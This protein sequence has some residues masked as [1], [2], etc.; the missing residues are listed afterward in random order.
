MGFYYVCGAMVGG[1]KCVART[2]SGAA[3]VQSHKL[4]RYRP[5]NKAEFDRNYRR[6]FGVL[7]AWCRGTGGDYFRE[8]KT[9]CLICNGVG[10]T[11]KPCGRKHSRGDVL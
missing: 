5:V 9:P 1:L 3:T 7:C 2:I 4:Y 8:E 6:V 11:E 10:F